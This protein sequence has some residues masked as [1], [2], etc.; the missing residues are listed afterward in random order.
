MLNYFTISVNELIPTQPSN[1]GTSDAFRWGAGGV[2]FTGKVMESTNNERRR[3]WK[4]WTTFL[5]T[6]Y[7]TITP[8]LSTIDTHKRLALLGAFAQHI[9]EGRYDT[10]GSSRQR[11]TQTVEVALRV[12]AQT[13]VLDGGHSRLV[14]TQGQLQLKIRRQLDSYKK[15]G[16]PPKSKLALP[17]SAVVVLHDTHTVSTPKTEVTLDLCI[18]AWYFLLRVGE[19]THTKK[20]KAAKQS[21]FVFRPSHFGGIMST[22]AQ[23]SQLRT[24]MHSVHLPP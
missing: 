2:L 8:N 5:A 10:R 12:I 19:Y 9:R 17:Y 15:D 20:P 3:F 7:P 1:T 14:T 16:P 6:N 21:N 11:R 24:C 18:I 22:L 23:L 4:H 13:I